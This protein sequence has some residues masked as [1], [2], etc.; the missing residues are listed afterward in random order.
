IR[1][2]VRDTEMPPTDTLTN[3]EIWQLA[4]YV[5]SLGQLPSEA[6]RGDAQNG[7]N[8]YR[9]KGRCVQCHIIRGEGGSLGP[10]L[11][12]VG[13]RRGADQLRRTLLNPE[14]TLPDGFL[15]VRM[16]T[17]DGRQVT[18]IRLNE[19]TFTIQVRDLN[20]RLYSFMKADLRDYQRD[21]GK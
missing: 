7:Q 17:N 6:V 15:Q 8:L 2:G 19:D 5:R 16:V 10:E 9:N 11:T 14:S 21:T 13:A 4:G 1:N 18:G 12:A 20:G 3:R